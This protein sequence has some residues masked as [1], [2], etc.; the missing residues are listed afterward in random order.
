MAVFSSLDG[1]EPD[2]SFVW[3]PDSFNPYGTV[4]TPMERVVPFPLVQRAVLFVS[5]CFS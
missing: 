1:R 4:L 3:G 2:L 5:F